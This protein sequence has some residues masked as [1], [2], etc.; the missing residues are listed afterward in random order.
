VAPIFRAENTEEP[1]RASV[2]PMRALR[3]RQRLPLV[4]AVNVP[5]CPVTIRLRGRLTADERVVF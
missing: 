5:G 4:T 1:E 3:N 2:Y